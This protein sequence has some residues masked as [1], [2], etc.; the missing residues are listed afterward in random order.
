[1][2][3]F[4]AAGLALFAVSGASKAFAFDAGPVGA[5]LLGILTA[6]GGGI[7]GDL[8]VRESQPCCAPSCTPSPPSLAR[9]S[10]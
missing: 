9:R 7:T 1:V 4:D 2:L 6:I 3:L 8:L 10:S 5:V